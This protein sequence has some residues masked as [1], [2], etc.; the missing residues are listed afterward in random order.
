MWQWNEVQEL[1]FEEATWLGEH[2]KL[3]PDLLLCSGE[4]I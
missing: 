1:L 3:M 2:P 4:K